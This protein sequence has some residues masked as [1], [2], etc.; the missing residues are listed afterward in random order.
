MCGRVG[1]GSPTSSAILAPRGWLRPTADPTSVSWAVGGL[2]P[3]ATGRTQSKKASSRSGAEDWWPF[4][5]LVK[6]G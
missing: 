1:V 3:H 2:G 5:K 4:E 6:T